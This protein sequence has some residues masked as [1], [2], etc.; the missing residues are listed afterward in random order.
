MQLPVHQFALLATLG[1]LALLLGAFFF[2]ALGYQPCAM[3]IWQRYPHAVAIVLGALIVVGLRHWVIYVA[4]FLAAATTAGLGVFHTGVERDWWEGPTSCSGSGL[5][6]A[7]PSSLL[8]SAEDTGPGIVMCDQVVWE[9]LSLSMA[10]WN[11]ILSVGLVILWLSA[12]WSGVKHQV[13]E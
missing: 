8:P 10:S 4:G 9:F 12:W 11:A 5:D 6:L 13:S 3:C 1:S 2:Q 7:S